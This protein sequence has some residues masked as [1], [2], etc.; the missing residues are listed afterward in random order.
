MRATER[1]R[2]SDQPLRRQ[3]VAWPGNAI[4][5]ALRRSAAHVLVDDVA[6]PVPSADAMH[7]LVR[8][9]RLRNG[10]P[11]TVTDGSG[12]WRPCVVAGSGL[13]P[14]GAVESEPR[15]APELT[16][17]VAPPNGDRLEWLVTKCTEVGVDRI[18]LV[19]AERSVVR[20]NGDRASKQIDRLRKLVVEAS[21]QSRRVWLPEIVG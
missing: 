6:A 13:E 12:R 19:D 10:E 5:D 8:V 20:W 1:Q 9:L 11:V 3:Q 17:A 7:H 21:M 4:T 18:V 14:V 2:G 16:I 15:P